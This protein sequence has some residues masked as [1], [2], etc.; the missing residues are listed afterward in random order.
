MAHK[1]R[2]DDHHALLIE[3]K[4]QGQNEKMRRIEEEINRINKQNEH[5][6][7]KLEKMEKGILKKME[8]AVKR[9]KEEEEVLLRQYEMAIAECKKIQLTK[10]VKKIREQEDWVELQKQQRQLFLK[11]RHQE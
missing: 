8:R 9:E 1:I 5:Q 10:Q 7:Q 6:L 4:E 11:A 2:T 3:R